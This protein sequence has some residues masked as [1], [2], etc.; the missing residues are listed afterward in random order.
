MGEWKTAYNEV[1]AG[2]A[3]AGV[4]PLFRFGIIADVQYADKDDGTNFLGTVRRYYRP[5]R[6][7]LQDAVSAWNQ[8]PDLRFIAQLGDVIDGCNHDNG[9]TDKAIQEVMSDLD[10]CN[11]KAFLHCMGNHEYYSWTRETIGK[12]RL[13]GPGGE[14]AGTYYDYVPHGG[15]RCLVLDPYDIRKRGQCWIKTIRTIAASLLT[16]KRV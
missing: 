10:Q 2:G 6:R 4:D 12:T 5:A 15:W 13:C 3:A 14:P 9:T 11:C 16:G 1:P 7:A 8:I